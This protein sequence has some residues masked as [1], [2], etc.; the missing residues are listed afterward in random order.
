MVM[1]GCE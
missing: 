1:W